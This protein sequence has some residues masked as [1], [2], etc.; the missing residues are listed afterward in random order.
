[1]KEQLKMEVKAD[2]EELKINMKVVREKMKEQRTKA[3]KD[4]NNNRAVENGR[5]N[6]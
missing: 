3:T 5:E 2:Q 4:I 6:N 1:M